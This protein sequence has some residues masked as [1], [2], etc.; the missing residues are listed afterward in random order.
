MTNV[1]KYMLSHLTPATDNE[2]LKYGSDAYFCG[3][4]KHLRNEWK[5]TFV[6][7]VEAW[8]VRNGG[9]FKI[10]DRKRIHGDLYGQFVKITFPT[11]GKR[12]MKEIMATLFR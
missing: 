12:N 2:V 11:Y 5:R 4:S 9:K 10:L 1:D 6:N 7:H 8:V 3:C